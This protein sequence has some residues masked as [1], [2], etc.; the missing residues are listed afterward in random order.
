MVSAAA[1]TQR[2]FVISMQPPNHGVTAAFIDHR[3]VVVMTGR[4]GQRTAGWRK[5]DTRLLLPFL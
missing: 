4:S 5:T 2:H 3:D 1:D